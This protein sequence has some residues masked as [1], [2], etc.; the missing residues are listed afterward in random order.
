MV[1][2]GFRR[3]LPA[4]RR[5]LHPSKGIP[6]GIRTITWKLIQTGKIKMPGKSSKQFQEQQIQNL[7]ILRN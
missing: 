6:P 3:E 2:M 5:E 4:R 7:S 1:G